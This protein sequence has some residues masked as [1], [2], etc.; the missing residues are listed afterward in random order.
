MGRGIIMGT[1][2]A[3]LEFEMQISFDGTRSY[4]LFVEV[5]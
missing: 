3:S 5:E 4:A 1:V 2:M